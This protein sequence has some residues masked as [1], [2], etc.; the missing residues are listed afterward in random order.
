MSAWI[1]IAA[2]GLCIANVHDGDTLTLCTREKVRV[3]NIDA[4]ELPDSPRC[5]PVQRQRLAGSKNPPWCDYKAGEQSRDALRAFLGSGSVSI[6][7]L[8]QDR[9]GRTLARI[10][11]GGRDAGDYLIRRGLARPWR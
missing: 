1:M 5:A 6:E 7:R 3:A 11:V 8:G 10:Y 4:P 9:Y 2:A